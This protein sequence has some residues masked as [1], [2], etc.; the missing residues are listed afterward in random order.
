MV[1]CQPRVAQDFWVMGDARELVV[2]G[3]AL[4]RRRRE[5]DLSQDALAAAA[6]VGSKHVSE[7]ERAKK[8]P[9]LTTF[10]KLAAGLGM[11]ATEL[12]ALVEQQ[13]AASQDA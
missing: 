12:M 4:R 1:E 13:L 5:L 9:R 7:L 8:D 11:S 2:F 10:M 3:R 6:G